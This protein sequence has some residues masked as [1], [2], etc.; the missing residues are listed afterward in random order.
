MIKIKQNI[1]IVYLIFCIILNFSFSILPISEYIVENEN[2]PMP[3]LYVS[4]SP[5]YMKEV[6]GNVSTILES[7]VFSDIIKSPPY[8]YNDTKVNIIEEISKINTSIERP[9]YEF[10]RDFKKALSTSRDANLD[11]LGYDL[12]INGTIKFFNYRYCLPFQ[13]YVDYNNNSDAKLFIKEYPTCSKFYAQTIKDNIKDHLNIPVEKINDIDAFDFLQNYDKKYYRFKNPDSQ[14]RLS[15]QIIHDNN[16]TFVPLSIEELNSIN[17]SFVSGDTLHTYFHIIKD[18][19]EQNEKAE[20]KDRTN[21]NNKIDWDYK[22]ENGEL[23]CR[24]DNTN[25]I[26]VIFFNKFFIEQSGSM[27]IAKCAQT[28]YKNDYRILIIT[29]QLW[30]EQYINSYIYAQALFPKLDIKYYVAMKNTTLNKLIYEYDKDYILDSKTCLPFKT[31]NDFLEKEPDRYG[32][33]VTHYR[34]KLFNPIPEKGIIELYYFRQDL[35]SLG[36]LKKSTDILIL[37][38]TVAYGPASLFLKTIQNN[39][40]AIIGSYSGNPRLNKENIKTLDASL[41]A[42][43]N[44]NYDFTEE[45][46]NLLNNGFL[47]YNIPFAEAFEKIENNDIP[48]AFKV[49][50]VD[51]ITKIYH[52]YDDNYYDEFVEEAKKIFTKYND[53]LECNKNNLN[54]V[55]ESDLCKFSDESHTYGGFKCGSD[56]KWILDSNNCGISYCDID[57]FYNRETKK[58]EL[59]T[60]ITNEIIEINTQEEKI[61]TI[62]PDKRYIFNL[63]TNLYAYIFKSPIDG[64]IYYPN[65]VEC[66]RFCGVKSDINFMYVNYY[67]NL[68]KSI[69]ITITSKVAN[70]NI[71]SEKLVSPKYSDILPF[72]GVS[73]F[74]FEITEDNYLYID[75]FDKN[76]KFYYTKYNDDLTIDDMINLNEEYFKEE[77]PQLMFLEKDNIFIGIFKQDLTFAKLYFYDKLP[78]KFNVR[79]KDKSLML[80]EPNK[81]YQ[82]NF[83][84]IYKPFMIRLNE[85]IDTI[86]KISDS[87]MEEQEI[88]LT[89]KYFIPSSQLYNGIIY[90]NTSEAL[91]GAFIEVLYNF[92]ENETD[93]IVSNINNYKINKNITLIEFSPPEKDKNII[94]ILIES[95]GT[96]Y[97]SAY[98]GFSKDGYF[99]NL[100]VKEKYTNDFYGIKLNNP[101]KDIQLEGNETYYIA[102]M[103]ENDDSQVYLTVK[104]Y[105]NSFDEL[106]V[107]IDEEYAKNV[108]D[109]ITSILQN[110]YIYLDIAK[111]PPEISGIP[112]Y[113]HQPIDLI[114]S[115]KDIDTKDR[116]FYEFYQEIKEILGIPRDGHLKIFGNST[117]KGF[118]FNYMTACLP[119]KYYVDKNENHEAK[120]Y[121]KYFEDCGV[122]LEEKIR[123]KIRNISDSKI[124]LHFIKLQ[125]PFD[126]IQNWG[127]YR[128]VRS[129]HGLF[130]LNKNRIHAFSLS[131]IPYGPDDLNM[132]FIFENNETLKLDYYI[133][134]PNFR[135]MNQLLGSNIFSEKEFDEFYENE[136]KKNKENII[137]PNIF[138]MIKKYKK[139]KGITI[140]EENSIIEWDYQT[141]ETHGIKCRVDY[142]N[143]L[144]ILVQES[145]S[146]K[147]EDAE[148]VIMKCTEK[149]HLNKFQIV[150]IEN[151]NGGG[152]GIISVILSQ[153]IQL[154]IQN[155]VYEAIKPSLYFNNQY[156]SHP[157]EFYNLDTCKPYDNFIDFLNGA[158]DNYSTAT[159]E[160]LHHKSKITDLIGIYQRQSLASYRHKYANNSNLKKPTDIIIFTDSFSFS[161]TSIFIKGL[162][163]EG[164]AITVGFNGNPFIDDSLFD[165]SQSPSPVINF[166]D[167][168]EYNN[169]KNLGFE[170]NG[171]TF[172]E[173]F[174][175]DYKNPNPI[176]REYK[177]NPVDYR[178]DIYEPYSDDKYKFFIDAAKKVFKKYNE[179]NECNPNN[180]NLVLE[181]DE[182]KWEDDIHAHGGYPCGKDEKWD[183]AT[184]KKLYCDIGYWYSKF[185]DK[186][187]ID[188]CTN[189]DLVKTVSL[190]SSYNDIITI[191]K[192]LN[193]EYVFT[194]ENDKYI[195]LFEA[196]EPGYLRYSFNNPCLS[197]IVLLST[198]YD[199]DTNIIHINYFR[200]ADKNVTIKITSAYN[201]DGTIF[202]LGPLNETLGGI[203]Y[204]PNDIIIISEQSIDYIY[205]F[206]AFD[207]STKI[208][209]AEYNRTM[210]I[211]DIINKNEQYFKEFDS[212]LLIAQKDKIF[213]FEAEAGKIINILISPKLGENYIYFNSK[214]TILYFSNEIEKYTLDFS[215]ND[216]NLM[217]HLS[218]SIKDTEI[219]I[220]N[221]ES[222]KETIL[223]SN[224]SYYSFDQTNSIYKGKLE[225]RVTKG[226]NAIIE[227]LYIIDVSKFDILSK[228]E[229][230]NYKITK[231]TII[232]FDNNN[233]NKDKNFKISIFS[234]TH[235]AFGY[236]YFT[237]YF[238]DNYTILTDEY[239]PTI[240]GKNYYKIEIYNENIDLKEG[241]SFC[242]FL[243]VDKAALKND[244]ILL[245]KED[246]EHE[247]ESEEEHEKEIEKEKEKEKEK[248]EEEGNE[249][250]KEEGKEEKEEEGK[251]EREEDWKE[252]EKEKE[253]EKEKKKEN[254]DEKESRG[255]NGDNNGKVDNNPNE[256]EGWHI[257]L[258]VIGS[259]LVV[260]GLV[261]LLIW[262]F[263]LSKKNKKDAFDSLVKQNTTSNFREM[264]DQN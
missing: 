226:E 134:I 167:T 244:V 94:D 7:Y 250:G 35:I 246:S 153:L 79:Y 20:N 77:L 102:L 199:F 262:I 54:L 45:Y 14:F 182:C 148:N 117:P 55:Y 180:T 121:I 214:S 37:T 67:R 208:L 5:E 49:N 238:K 236:T 221:N 170:V 231:P 15:I 253:K 192:D 165:A 92:G 181:S 142:E 241:E 156:N 98:G 135:Q 104:Y 56:G 6:L 202:S 128:L 112:N 10:Y 30:E 80:L 4:V 222:D 258:I 160:I 43:L 143:E 11:I 61:Y 64:V 96:K 225:I 152:K 183:N 120:I 1:L 71:H 264:D 207:K 217:L 157:E 166:A 26:N 86:L 130:T 24:V 109:N 237:Y 115:L 88:S 44:T 263:V 41:D 51:E 136:I 169:L 132:E 48:M 36:H 125:N 137:I 201:F 141:L 122:H 189:E 245:T 93:I 252:E 163:N 219:S 254:E 187:E 12:P 40:G 22:T 224:N 240:T 119:F 175:E 46:K 168:P 145:F 242:L 129:P 223:N 173:T 2:N 162:Q 3:E 17:L 27:T 65:I 261:F 99:Y 200:N 16:L 158:T 259:L 52:S 38:D 81:V 213:I 247:E 82:L 114:E 179:E 185:S 144:N 74:I 146:L 212:G 69:N 193:I 176:P 113:T 84:Q 197:S 235:T 229:Y 107:K 209:Y 116:I 31:W 151:L 66:S 21:N 174:E 140:E 124:A 9:F 164:G 155:R 126:Y 233:N 90:I 215:Y 216:Y 108:I 220:Y 243:Y 19:N 13:F 184:C 230:T 133:Y 68:N 62:E 131:E 105:K 39:G 72:S 33:N 25:K 255:S 171:I 59:D 161:A 87:S 50:K 110:N 83:S 75:S 70:I 47:V 232:K 239:D 63:N 257:A 198:K 57:Y 147:Q 194:I 23:K 139:K 251:K 227:F 138:E 228:K 76:I 203:Q 42:T 177:L 89:N 188:P 97:L 150:V 58:C 53:N 29:S 234:E 149:F 204:I 210:T 218:S 123:R 100:P 85:K 260:G 78:E 60:C 196:S 91:K 32:D 103:V 206:K 127:K 106:Y 18:S 172:G 8:P 111:N 249:E 256:L 205:Y 190:T 28:F 73:I 248:V 154:K 186:C 191:S 118:K 211:S 34:T 159:E 195:Y 95:K 178:S 101:L